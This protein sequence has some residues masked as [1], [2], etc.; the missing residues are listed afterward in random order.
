[1]KMKEFLE[2]YTHAVWV[3]ALVLVAVLWGLAL[4]TSASF[5]SVD[6]TASG[7]PDTESSSD[8]S[9]TDEEK[10]DAL[11]DLFVESSGEFGNWDEF[12]DMPKVSVPASTSRPSGGSQ[13]NSQQESHEPSEEPSEETPPV[14][15]ESSIPDAPP[16]TS[17]D[18]GSSGE[19]SAPPAESSVPST[20]SEPSGAVPGGPGDGG[21]GTSGGETP[22]DAVNIGSDATVDGPTPDNPD[23]PEPEQPENPIDAASMVEGPQG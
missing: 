5:E 18:T 1:M 10:S 8:I 11:D 12:S 9:L 21:T 16:A 7:M 19:P 23:A 15:Q 6:K 4:F 22:G 17:V 14:Q 3:Q 13:N 2:K 20:P